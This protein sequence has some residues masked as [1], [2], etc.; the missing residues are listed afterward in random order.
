VHRFIVGTG[1][2]G[3]TLLSRMIACNRRVASLSEVFNGLDGAR[4]FQA[5]PMPGSEFRDMV[6]AVHP[7]LQMVLER[8]YAVPEV[9]YPL[10]DP[11]FRFDRK[12]G[13]PWILGTTLAELT[14]EPDALYEVLR[15]FTASQPEQ[16][17]V[18]HATA[19]FDWLAEGLGCDVWVER[20]GAAI[21][22]MA[23]LNASF[24]DARFL[25][26]HRA[27]EEAALSMREHHAFRL[28]IMLTYQLPVGSGRS[29]EALRAAAPDEGEISQLLE[30]RPEASWFGRWWTDQV[31]RGFRGLRGL[32]AAQYREVRFEA[33]LERPEQ[34]LEGIA[35]FLQLPD[36][37]GPWRGEAAALIHGIPPTRLEQLP[38][39]ER[40][41]LVEACLPGNKLLGRA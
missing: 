3:S 15:A 10:D 25:H 37:S 22:Y 26:I 31:L 13:V 4:R 2:C 34:V 5:E 39:A 8:G 9:S 40:G 1:R 11:A 6:C 20:S 19:L 16:G 23:A 32:D 18:A 36:P 28:A 35:H 29:L 21:D 24:A 12:T 33:L 27:G 30:S 38:E 17:A 14:D 7:F 41:A